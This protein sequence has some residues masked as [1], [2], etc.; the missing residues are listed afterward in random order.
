MGVH[1]KSLSIESYSATFFPL[2]TSAVVTR[3]FSC[4]YYYFLWKII[5]GNSCAC[6]WANSAALVIIISFYKV[7]LTK[8]SSFLEIVWWLAF[9]NAELKN[10]LLISTLTWSPP[11]VALSPITW[12]A[13]AKRYGQLIPFLVNLAGSFMKLWSSSI[14]IMVLIGT[15]PSS[16]TSSKVL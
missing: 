12:W 1:L 16:S 3:D 2:K 6:F 14:K 11:K 4:F 5:T 9:T 7:P 15:L 8:M 10:S 13:A